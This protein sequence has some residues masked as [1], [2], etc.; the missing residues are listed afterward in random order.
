[1][2]NFGGLLSI[3]SFLI[4]EVTYLFY[5]S[6]ET[7]KDIEHI[8]KNLFKLLNLRSFKKRKIHAYFL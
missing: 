1:M 7:L 2:I 3:F 6:P 8:L 5:Y 4:F